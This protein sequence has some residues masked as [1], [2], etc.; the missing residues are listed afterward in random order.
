MK[1]LQDEWRD[2]IDEFHREWIDL[3]ALAM[4][5][6]GLTRSSAKSIAFCKV[7]RLRAN[8]YD[9]PLVPLEWPP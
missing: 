2:E 5:R 3:L 1:T 6:Q 7:N 8:L 4:V 9:P